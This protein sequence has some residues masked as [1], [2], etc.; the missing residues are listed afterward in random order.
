MTL[1]TSTGVLRYGSSN[2]VLDI[3]QAISDYYRSLM[4]KWIKTNKQMYPAHISVVRK[5]PVIPK[6]EYWGKHG[7]EEIEFSYSNV[8]RNGTVY[9]WIDA[10][11]KRLEEVRLE[12]GL[13][14]D[15]PYTRPPDGMLETFHITIGN[16][17]ELVQ[18]KKSRG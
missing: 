13:T 2:V 11:S 9:Y 15:S 5:E 7:G 17:K 10:W 8:V 4:P 1:F 14:V 3:D 16:T 12:L 18:Q 6:M